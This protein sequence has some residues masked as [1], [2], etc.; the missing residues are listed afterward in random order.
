VDSAIK[1]AVGE[2]QP[3]IIAH[4]DAYLHKLSSQHDK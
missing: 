4:L 3:L 2:R 1:A